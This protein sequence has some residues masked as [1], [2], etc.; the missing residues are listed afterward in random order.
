MQY[1]A[2]TTEEYIAQLPEERREPITKLVKLVRKSL[3]KGYS[4]SI[5]YGMIGWG[6]PLS[7]YPDTYNGQPI[8][9]VALASQK[10]HMALYLMTVYGNPEI[11][12]WFREEWA[13]T[14]KKLDMGKSCLRFKRLEDIDLDIISKTLAMVTPEQLIARYEEVK[15]ISGKKPSARAV[16][17]TVKEAP[18]SAKKKAAAPSAAKKAAPAKKTPAKSAKKKSATR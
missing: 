10:N 5:A 13:K 2:S 15:G 7:R 8:G 14:G 11:E 6:I 17:N 9:P 3:P 16:R 1:K 12:T 4:E 18:A